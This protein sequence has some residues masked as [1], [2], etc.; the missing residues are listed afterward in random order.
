MIVNADSA[1]IIIVMEISSPKLLV[2]LK[3]EKRRT[4]K[5]SAKAS[6]L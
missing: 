1:L 3:E 6:A 5:P 4:A 2:P